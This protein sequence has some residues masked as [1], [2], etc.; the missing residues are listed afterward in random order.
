MIN[1]RR[2]LQQSTIVSLAPT[3]PAFLGHAAAAAQAGS[4][5][6]GRV[7][8]VVQLNGGND[9]INTVV[10]YKDEAYDQHR[11]KLR[12]P[13]RDL[14]KLNDQIALHG[15][16]RSVNSLLEDGRLAIVQG[17]GY[18]NPNRSHF[19]SMAIWHAASDD[20]EEIKSDNGWLGRA[21]S[22]TSQVGPNAMHVGI[23]DLPLALRGRRCHATTISSPD[24][25][26]LALETNIERNAPSSQQS[27]DLSAFVSRNVA[28]AYATARD[29]QSTLKDSGGPRYPG[30]QLAQRLKMVSRMIKSDGTARVYYTS[31]SGYDTHAVQLP[32]HAEL[33]GELSSSLKA[34]LDD[35]RESQLEDRVVVMAFSEFG[36]RVEENGSLGTDHGTAGPV[37]LAGKSVQAGLVGETPSLSDLEDG[38]LKHS[39]DFR[40]VYA[41]ILQDWLGIAAH[42]AGDFR[43]LEGLFA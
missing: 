14:I 5:K 40:C 4:A 2:F 10:P 36:R 9:G 23:E 32:V 33:L 6:Q 29:L 8:V 42:Q 7:L 11:A 34:F 41:S 26:S 35:M 31:Q 24:D 12:L 13:E 1:R 28:N 22:E 20:P 38:D 39:I 27:N 37:I 18:P 43:P 15:R 16:L 25:L 3:M 21:L 19:E 17:V 30:S